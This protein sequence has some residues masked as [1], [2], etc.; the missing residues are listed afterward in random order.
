MMMDDR[1]CVVDG[2]VR[3]LVV[4]DHDL[5]RR[6][7]R[8]LLEGQDGL[9]VVGEAATAGMA[10]VAVDEHR[11]DVVLLDVLLPDGSGIDVCR[12]LRE[13]HPDVRVLFLTSSD[14]EQVLF[15]AIVAGAAGFLLKQSA[16]TDVVSAVRQ[17]A[18]GGSLLD[19][20]VTERVLRRVRATARGEDP[21]LA[22]L[23]PQE[24]RVLE[25]LTEG[26]TNREIAGQLGLAEKTVKNY[27][28][29]ILG[30]LGMRRR[31]EAAV[32]FLGRTGQVPD[33]I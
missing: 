15:D 20:A 4:D 23:T 8:A 13:R 27:V 5:V 1:R 14:D 9:E 30:K 16:D 26:G 24:L 21:V 31:T 33:R 6:G 3:I 25:L 32:W 18:A 22:Q 10:L 7:L 12:R 17:V 29:A 11:P 28:S 19:P 2:P